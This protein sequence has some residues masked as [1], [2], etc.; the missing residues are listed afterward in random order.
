M[1]QSYVYILTNRKHGTLYTGVTSNIIKRV[2]EHKEG[3][4]DGFSK[5][6]LLTKLVYYEIFSHIREAIV[7]EKHIKKWRRVWKIELIEKANVDWHDLYD[8]LF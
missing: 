8:Q 6:Y 5:K 3:L 2:Y 7:R 4:V 1:L